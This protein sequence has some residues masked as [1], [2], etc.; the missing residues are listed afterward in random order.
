LDIDAGVPR[1][2]EVLATEHG[3]PVPILQGKW[4][5]FF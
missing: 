4:L 3:Q 5:A 2:T 1:E